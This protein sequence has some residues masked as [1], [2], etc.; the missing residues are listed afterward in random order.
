MSRAQ[1][2]MSTGCGDV[3]D[4]IIRSQ[5]A[6]WVPRRQLVVVGIGGHHV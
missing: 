2:S 4:W 5:T 1:Q 3:Y 6:G